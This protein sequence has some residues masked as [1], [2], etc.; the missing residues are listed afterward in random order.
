MKIRYN[1]WEFKKCSLTENNS[2]YT[3]EVFRYHSS[4]VEV[5]IML[6]YKAARNSKRP[7]TL[8]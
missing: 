1:T 7:E 3:C 4:V 2:K 6:E 5:S 8:P